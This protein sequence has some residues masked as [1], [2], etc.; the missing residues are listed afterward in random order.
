MHCMLSN[1]LLTRSI[2]AL[3]IALFTTFVEPAFAQER[4]NR[5]H[6]SLW[7]GVPLRFGIDDEQR[8]SMPV[9]FS[10]LLGELYAQRPTLITDAMKDLV[11]EATQRIAVEGS[12]A[13]PGSD[14]TVQVRNA[15]KTEKGIGI[16]LNFHPDL[17]VK[18][19]PNE[20]VNKRMQ[21]LARAIEEK[22]IAALPDFSRGY[23]KK[24][25]TDRQSD[26][27]KELSQAIDAIN[28]LRTEIARDTGLPAEKA[29]EQLA[30]ISRQQIAAELALVG[31]EAREKA[32]ARE[33]EK[34]RARM[35]DSEAKDETVSTLQRLLKLR[36]D[37]LDR[38]KQLHQTGVSTEQDVRTAEA[39]VLTAK[40]D[41]DKTRAALK[42]AAGGEQL[43]AF[44]AELSRL[45]IDRAET[46]A[47]R[48]WLEKLSKETSLSLTERREAER[49][50]E[51][52]R[53][54]L[55]KAEHNRED[56]QTQ[57]E[58]IRKSLENIQPI[59]VT[60]PDESATD[61]SAH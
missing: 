9:S 28:Q 25:L 1:S 19:S 35:D 61:D 12:P 57:L 39:D 8:H 30:E 47:R 22:T 15:L 40:I 44:T 17:K 49:R 32:I 48:D 6:E 36:M 29:A 46:Q 34:C 3:T 52:L 53:P 38:E 20:D 56:Y 33:I 54:K 13:V 50:L 27:E 42:R 31:M 11:P 60:L 7:T 5:I 43:D 2:A 10:A 4:S 14:V 59:H 51:S 16:V 23:I 24:Q 41:L 45:A 55:A 37:R 58:E 21:T 18:L 26:L